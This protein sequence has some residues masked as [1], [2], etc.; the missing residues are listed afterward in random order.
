MVSP[1]RNHLRET[2]DIGSIKLRIDLLHIDGV[3]KQQIALQIYKTKVYGIMLFDNLGTL[4]S[5][6]QAEFD[7]F[8]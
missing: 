4:T 7:V 5:W 2:Y 8:M 3:F 6:I 1:V